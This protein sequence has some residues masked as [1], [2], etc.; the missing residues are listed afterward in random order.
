MRLRSV[1]VCWSHISDMFQNQPYFRAVV[2]FKE[3]NLYLA[4]QKELGSELVCKGV[5]NTRSN[6][7]DQMTFLWHNS[8]SVFVLIFWLSM[9]V[10]IQQRPSS[11]RLCV[12]VMCV[13]MRCFL[14]AVT[15]DTRCSRH[16]KK[17]HLLT[18]TRWSNITRLFL[19]THRS[20]CAHTYTHNQ[21]HFTLKIEKCTF[22]QQLHSCVCSRLFCFPG[23]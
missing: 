17:K 18:V 8:A 7:R 15:L 4:A 10:C 13:L 20:T 5:S 12:F 22:N 1:F 14:A 21:L 23:A 11:L 2:S 9:D 6:H 16:L 3:V 19:H